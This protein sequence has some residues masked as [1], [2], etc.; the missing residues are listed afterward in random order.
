M[1]KSLTAVIVV[2]MIMSMILA[3]CAPTEEATP[4]VVV[5]EA[6]VVATEEPVVATEEPV[7]EEPAIGSPE[8][9]IKVLFVPSVDANEIIAG[10]ELLAQ[11][12][13]EATGLTFEVIVPTSY[14][15]TIEEMCASPTDTMGFIPGL[16][17]VLANQVCGVDVAAKAVRFGYDWYAAMV[18][19]RR[20]SGLTELSQLNG[21]RWAYPDAASTSGY[22]Y[23]QFMYQE[24]S[25]VPGEIIEAG[26]HDAALMAV[27]N[28]EADFGTAFYSPARVDG[29]S[30]D[31]LPGQDADVPADLIESCVTTED[32]KAL[33]CGNYEIRDARRNLR[34]TVADAGQVLGVLATTPM[35]PNDTISFG[36]EFPAGIRDQII[37]A[38]FEFAANNPEG[39]AEAMAPYSWTGINPATDA[40][41]DPIRNAITASGFTL[42]DLGE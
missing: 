11:T 22:L 33:I 37:T 35:I 2:L 13:N 4:E 5:T 32:G 17:Y 41:Y 9:P 31:W 23:P 7:V 30:I 36:P 18:V 6:P 19:V 8:H 20:D 34:S 28:G 14:A 42:E 12:L 1:K 24:N 16:G 29:A 40:D 10:G 27:Y 38:L 15:A 26:S 21:L 3:A 39:F 25:V